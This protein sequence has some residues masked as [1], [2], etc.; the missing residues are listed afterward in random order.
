LEPPKRHGRN[1]TLPDDSEAEVDIL[2]WIK[3]QIEKSQPSTIYENRTDIL[4]YGTS[5][6]GKVIT[7]GWVD[8]LLMRHKDELVE[9][10]SKPQEDA[11]LQVSGEFLFR[12]ISGIE[13]AVQ[14][15]VWDLVVSLDEVGIGISEWEDRKS[16]KVDVPTAISNQTIDHGVNWNLKHITL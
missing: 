3:H 15:R 2:A 14:I 9:T 13:E 11:R 5:K 12:T 4:Y 10:I 1:N 8:S 6:F 16:K 7:L